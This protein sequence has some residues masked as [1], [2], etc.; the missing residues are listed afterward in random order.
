MAPGEISS[1]CYKGRTDLFPA[2]TLKLALFGIFIN[3]DDHT[4]CFQV[5]FLGNAKF[6]DLKNIEGN[7]IQAESI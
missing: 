6:A 2:L 7:T 4:K 5:G 1:S 3:I